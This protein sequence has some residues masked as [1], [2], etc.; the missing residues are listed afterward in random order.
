M[1]ESINE[2]KYSADKNYFIA[3]SARMQMRNG[4]TI[5]HISEFPC[6]NVTPFLEGSGG[7]RRLVDTYEFLCCDEMS[8]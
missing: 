3:S 5:T 4:D 8:W 6:E 1:P 2:T 7:D